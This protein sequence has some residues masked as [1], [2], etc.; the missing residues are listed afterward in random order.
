[1]STCM[2]SAS[3]SPVEGCR[4]LC[5]PTDRDHGVAL[6]LLKFKSAST[7]IMRT[8][9]NAGLPD[10]ELPGPHKYAAQ[11]AVEGHM[12]TKIPPKDQDKGDSRNHGLYCRVLVTDVKKTHKHQD[13][14]NLHFW[15][16]NVGTL[17][18]M[19]SF[20]PLFFFWAPSCAAS[21]GW[22]FRR[23]V[24]GPQ[25]FTALSWDAISVFGGTPIILVS[26]SATKKSGTLKQGYGI[27]LQIRVE[28]SH[29]TFNTFGI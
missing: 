19:W 10:E 3:N 17:M 12:N 27:S 1:M 23:P 22:P 21:T 7:K 14:T 9:V 25:V 24:T 2:A 28:G 4:T 11:K 26:E 16:Q 6:Y 13:P 8:S 15:Y 20:R 18:F 29:N 5:S